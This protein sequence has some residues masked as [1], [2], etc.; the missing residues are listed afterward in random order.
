MA[1]TIKQLNSLRAYIEANYHP[2]LENEEVIV[3]KCYGLSTKEPVDLGVGSRERNISE[4]LKSVDEET[5]QEAL[6]NLIDERMMTDSL[7]YNASNV[8]RQVFHKIRCDRY[9][10]PTRNT[11][12][13]LCFGLSLTLDEALKLLS[14]AGYYLSESNKRDVVI[15]WFLEDEIYDVYEL[16]EILYD[17]KYE[18]IM[19][20]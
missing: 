17:N 14:K 8:S 16:D 3:E 19:N 10:K 18:L 1:L 13:R 5:W 12:I 20:Y 7:V 9:Y 4:R 6:L 11:A 15:R 2:A